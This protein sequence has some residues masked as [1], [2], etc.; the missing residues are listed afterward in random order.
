[1]DKKY[2]IGL[3]IGTNSIGWTVV[4]KY[5]HIIRV[6][7]QTGIGVRLFRE[8]QTAAER[9]TFRTTRR[10]LSR[11]RWR[12]RLLREIFDEPI[13]AIDE[14]F[15][16]RQ[17]ASSLAP[18]DARYQQAFQ[19]F[20]D[21]TDQAFYCKYP[22][23]YHLRQALMTESRQ[24]DIRE[25]YL[26]LHQ[27]IKYRG[28]FL[29]GGAAKDFQ[30]DKLDLEAYFTTINAQL[31]GIYSDGSVQLP[32]L[33][34]NQVC[35]EL[36]DTSRT[37]SDRKNWLVKELKSYGDSQLKP[38][39]TQIA[40]AILGFKTDFAKIMGINDPEK[41]LSFNLDA[42]D[43]HR[44]DV[45]E[46]LTDE[47]IPLVNLLAKLHT[48][49]ELAAI[50]PDGQTLSGKMVEIYETHRK[51]LKT[52][53]AFIRQLSDRQQR[54]ALK[55]AYDHYID[56][57]LN[58]EAF[59]SEVKAVLEKQKPLTA[60]GQA[61]KKAMDQN[62]FLLKQR[63]KANIA[64]PYQVQQQ[65]MDQIIANQSKY[66]PWLATPNPVKSRRTIAPYKLDE[67]VCF[68]VN[69]YVG[70]L[71]QSKPGEV[72]KEA[73]FAWMTRKNPQS[74]V[75]ITPW[76]FDQQVDRQASANAF[77]QRMKT[78][79]TYLLG[80][81]VIPKNSLLYQKYE[82]LNE[83]NNVRVNG[84]WLDPQRKQYLFKKLFMNQ[85]QSVV[86]VKAL[87]KTLVA[88][89]ACPTLPTVEGLA[90]PKRFLSQLTTYHD[91]CKL[92][93]DDIQR[94]DRQADI[95][96]IINWS[97][98]FEDTAIFKEKLR[99]IK[100]LSADQIRRLSSR[101]R[102]RGW[103][104]FSAKL[105]CGL[106][107]RQGNTVMDE[108]WQTSRN[109]MQIIRQSDFQTA[110]AA[111]N[112]QDLGRQDLQRVIDDLYTSPQ[113]KKAIRQV[114]AVV[115]DIQKAMHGKAPSWLFVEVAKGAQKNP[116]RTQSR[117]SKLA[118]A[119]QESARE[120]VDEAVKEQLL[121]LPDDRQTFSD[122]LVLYFQQNG[123]D[124][125][126]GEPLDFE[127]LSNYHIDHI[128]PQAVVKDDSL[129]NRVLTSNQANLEKGAHV[130]TIFRD[131]QE[132][133]WQELYR[134]GLISHRKLRNLLTTPDDLDD[135][136][137]AT[138]FIARQL[139]ETRQ[140]IK[141]VMEVLSQYYDT[142]E[143][144]LISIKA[145]LSHQFRQ[146]LNLPK[147]RAL[148][149]Y[150]HAQDA[151]LAARIGTYLLQR[152]PNLKRFFV[153][154]DFKKTHFD[155]QRRFNFIG[156]MISREKQPYN[157]IKDPVT[158]QVIWDEEMEIGDCQ[159]KD[160]EQPKHDAT[161]KMMNLTKIMN[162][163]HI[164]V[165]HEVYENHGALFNQT[166]YPASQAHKK[167]LIPQ[168]AEKPIELYGGH[169]SEQ[170]GYM[171]IIRLLGKRPSYKVM[172]VP[173]RYVSQLQHQDVAEQKKLLYKLFVP[174]LTSR[175]K[176]KPFEVVV[177]H[178]CLNQPVE[179]MI[180]GQ[181]HRF[182]LR[183]NGYYQNQQQLILS[184]VAQRTLA[185]YKPK[186][187][188]LMAVYHEI[189]KQVKYYFPLYK[190]N[191]FQ[192]RL[193]AA[194]E[195]LQKRSTVNSFSITIGK[196]GKENK[197]LNLGKRELLLRL[198]GGLHANATRVDLKD[199]GCTG[200]FGQLQ[201]KNGIKLTEQAVLIHESPTGLFHRRVRLNDL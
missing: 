69:Y 111:V 184:L 99:D 152:Y 60:T 102:Y 9:R 167:K 27:I 89:V 166:I 15:F 78:T 48:A 195:L 114:L 199:I 100:W 6:K 170:A 95:E 32:T 61:M 107:D 127:R 132:P 79:D 192:S 182:A 96:K 97:T 5:G 189:C 11:R 63:T 120:L 20:N 14:N 169:S 92:L 141:L 81:D 54:L 76:N 98:I 42:L 4:D 53:K 104:R 26:A 200:R 153:Y 133:V 101:P 171:A 49:L 123:R 150:H 112:Q 108:L 161:V 72:T 119:Y 29:L 73:K 143:T 71:V 94:A 7:G 121:T 83:L 28:H 86:T 62:A 74:T 67:L 197:T 64:I 17:K 168:K 59:Y 172:R 82:V 24:F 88:I 16:A 22:T 129:D 177:P 163:K 85:P 3:D 156:G 157:L 55:Q 122:R 43:D 23:I 173:V 185:G 131:K 68:R 179:D 45:A 139:V 151:Y 10:R 140:V 50:L 118:E 117:Q 25:I 190:M 148:N 198:L 33:D 146:E 35:Q 113:N 40:N 93:P 147:L 187:D 124:I 149:D 37:Q 38:I 75:A 144:E 2:G 175:N 57:G 44:D 164:L 128:I 162:L 145:G 41:A 87:Q 106:H 90:N 80:E 135:R 165:T 77:I 39:Y 70:P 105:L 12:L 126:T 110:I 65:E 8:G 34:W 174:E 103:G 66:Y 46:L 134:V 116:Q 154:G 155:L 138:G 91:F 178:V 125:Y 176:V 196:N 130:P 21:R 183:T 137:R 56:Q 115:T 193:F 191:K 1:M 186:D 36:T 19:L 52:Y 51:Q 194:E 201:V 31:A 58:R 159:K 160:P 47:Q 84:D 142:T 13:S 18:G 30:P 181:W 109:F 136:G 158:H 180:K 188:E